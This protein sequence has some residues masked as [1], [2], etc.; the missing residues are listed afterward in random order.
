MSDFYITLVSNAQATSTISNFKTH[1]ASPLNFNKPYEVALCSIIYPTSHDLIAKTLESDGKYE[2]EFS[3]WYDK[4]EFKCSI[5]HCSFDSPLE[6]ITILNYTLTNIVSRATN[7]TK[8]K[9]DLFS[10]DSIFK[11]ITVPKHSKVTKI[12]LSD[13][14][15]YF[16][17]LNKVLT[18][19]PVIG[20]YSVYSGSDLMYIYSD[21]LVEPQITS[22]MKVP[23]LKVITISTGIMGNVDQ[24]F[25]NPLYVPVRSSYVDQIGIQIKNDRDQFIP[26]NSGK[27]VVVLHFRPIVSSL[28]G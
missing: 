25:T 27:I 5:P 22:H 14:L 10:Y 28:D 15:S 26:F 6:L 18:T 12:E 3:V 24:S 4:Q 16:L 19:F 2:N 1:L 9:I 17:G 23:L 20:Q 13:R 8:V 11:R 21:G 7:D